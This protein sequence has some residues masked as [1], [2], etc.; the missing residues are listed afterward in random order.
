L[1][2]IQQDNDKMHYFLSPLVFPTIAVLLYPNTWNNH[3]AVLATSSTANTAEI[4]VFRANIKDVPGLHSGWT[5]VIYLY[6]VG[7]TDEES[8]GAMT[9]AFYAGYTSGLGDCSGE[10]GCTIM[11]SPRTVCIHS[12]SRAPDYFVAAWENEVFHEADFSGMVEGETM[13][14]LEGKTVISE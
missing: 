13:S 8:G 1:V 10:N 11:L 7:T 12:M 4:P 5:G 3:V 2:I 14:E 6:G 9:T